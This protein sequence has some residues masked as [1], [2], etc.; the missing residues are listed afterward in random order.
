MASR[1]LIT[2]GT[3]PFAQRVGRLLQA[4]YTVQFG[5]ADEVPAVLLHTGNYFQLPAINAPA[6]EHELLRTCMDNGIDTLIPLGEKEIRL[7]VRTQELFAEYGIAIWIPDVALFGELDV[8]SHPDRRCPL[9]VLNRGMAVAG[10]QQ[11]AYPDTL[12]GVFAELGPTDGLA[13]CCVAD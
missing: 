6:F 4:S 2:Q 1:V 13:L 8:I 12:S 7:L 11:H 5:S 3:R 10:G 9:V